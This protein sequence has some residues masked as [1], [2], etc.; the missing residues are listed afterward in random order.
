MKK[1]VAIAIPLLLLVGA[2]L[3]VRQAQHGAAP[4]DDDDRAT[5]ATTTNA[6]PAATGIFIS[7][8]SLKLAGIVSQPLVPETLT[9]SVVSFGNL[10][11]PTGLV[12]L[13]NELSDAEI[14][15]QLS[16]TQ[17]KRTRTLFEQNQSA[18]QK[19][20]ELAESQLR[21]DR[22]KLQVARR[23][24]ELEW[25]TKTAALDAA[26]RNQLVE[27]L[28]RR[29]IALAKVEIPAGGNLATVPTSAQLIAF[30]TDS[31][32][33]AAVY[34]EATVVDPR[35]QGRGFILEIASPPSGWRPGTA[36]E[37]HLPTGGAVRR[38]WQVPRSAVLRHLGQTW[39]YLQK[40]PGKFARTPVRL[41]ALSG[42]HWFTED[43]LAAADQVVVSGAQ[44]LLSEELKSQLASGD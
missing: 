4:H 32:L 38:G 8:E 1:A 11:D 15:V 19:S 2:F 35:T 29:E 42:D 30:G 12:T 41:G 10:L 9:A 43:A 18:P 16:E 20:L 23:K 40:N 25:G 22:L 5:T 26:S 17:A 3:L 37:A 39:I 34:S 31:T 27:R 36:V 14:A 33:D 24:L 6:A 28:L 7:A 44:A 13:D 21:T